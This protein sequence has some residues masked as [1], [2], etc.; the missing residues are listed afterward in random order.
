MANYPTDP[1]SVV[2]DRYKALTGLEVLQDFDEMSLR[3]NIRKR[4]KTA[5]DAY[6]WPEF[7]VIGEQLLLTS[8]NIRTLSP[9]G[10]PGAGVALAFDADQ[11]LSI[12]KEDPNKVLNPS[13]YIFVK[14]Q[15]TFSA[16]SVKIISTIDLDGN[17]VFVTYKKDFDLVVKTIINPNGTTGYFGT[18]VGDTTEIPRFILEYVCHGAYCDYLKS[19]GQNQKSIIDEQVADNLLTRAIENLESSGRQHRNNIG[20][21]RPRSQFNRHQGR[22]AQA[23]TLPGQGRG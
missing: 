4:F 17:N 11:V 6:P 1:Y 16:P 2:Q 10:V 5:F 12:Q 15:D 20:Q 14:N 3:D 23:V 18:Q 7:R 21:E 13:E 22:Q 8:N 19:D 9:P